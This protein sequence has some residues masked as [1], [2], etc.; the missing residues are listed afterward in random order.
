MN[1]KHQ[2]SIYYANVNVKFMERVVTQI[3]RGITINVDVSVKNE[4]HV[5]KIMFGI[6]PHLTIKMENI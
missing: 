2:Q 4:T 6:L 3:N 5:I 1:R